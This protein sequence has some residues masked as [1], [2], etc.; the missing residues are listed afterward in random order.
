MS[1]CPDIWNLLH[2]AVIVGIAGKVPGTLELDL[3]IDYLR[4]RFPDPGNLLR[5][6]LEGCRECA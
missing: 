1:S 4:T 2:D 5:L 6:L 3:Q